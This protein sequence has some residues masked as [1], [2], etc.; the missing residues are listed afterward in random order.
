MLC[1]NCNTKLNTNHNFCY[2]CGAKVIT[3]KI[4]F[5]NV[6][7]NFSAQFFNYDN[8]F[9]KTFLDLTIKPEKVIAGYLDGLRKRYINVIQY[10][11]ISLTITGLHFFIL[12]TFFENPFDIQAS[13]FGIPKN[14]PNPNSVEEYFSKTSEFMSKYI[15]IIYILSIPISAIGSWLAY[16]IY[17]K[18][19]NYTE[20]II[21]NTYYAAH[22]LI[23]TAV[24]AI[25][26]VT[27]GA[28]YA[29]FSTISFF[30]AFI[31]FWYVLKRVYKIPWLE[32]IAYIFVHGVFYFVILLLFLI[33]SVLIGFV[34]A[35][36]T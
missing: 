12:T 3:Q 14:I 9:L 22:Y 27:F 29:N 4:T 16:R 30:L 31:Y 10:L 13:Q 33:L 24:L 20:H 35:L 7:E 17:D 25:V 5:K 1:K 36:I 15:S 23:A 19:Y 34:Y 32:S 18:R 11:A 28:S 2:E 6:M 8:K 21:I 26:F